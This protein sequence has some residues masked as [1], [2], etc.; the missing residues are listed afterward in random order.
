MIQLRGISKRFGDLWANADIDLDVRRGECHAVVGENGAGKTT[1]MQVLWG[2]WQPDRGEIRIEGVPKRFASPRDALRAGI[3]VVHQQLLVFPRLTAFENIVAGASPCRFLWSW[4]AAARSHI[5]RWADLFGFDLPLDVPVQELPFAQRQQIELLRALH[6]GA[7]ILILDEPTSLLA[8]PEV[9][10]LLGLLRSL[11][12]Q[13]RTLLFVSHRLSEVFALADTITVL[14]KGRRVV[15]LAQAETSPE[16]VAR[17]MVGAAWGEGSAGADEKGTDGGG[18]QTGESRRISVGVSLGDDA[19]FESRI[20]P[21]DRGGLSEAAAGEAA[22]FASLMPALELRSVSTAPTRDE[23][24]LRDVAL[25]MHPKEI[26]GIGG[27]VGNGQRSLAR[28]VAGLAPLTS[29]RILVQGEDWGEL[30][31]S[32]R[33]RRGFRLLPANLTEE[34]FCPAFSL[35]ENFL[36]GRHREKR[37][38]SGGWL[39]KSAARRWALEELRDGGVR[40]ENV[41]Q[42]LETLSGGN[43][44]RLGLVRVLTGSPRLLLLEQPGRGLDLSGQG[45]L[46]D[47]LRELSAGGASVLVISYD[48]DELMALCHR[49]GILYRGRLMGILP[50][51]ATARERLALWMTGVESC[52]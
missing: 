19:A 38:E 9:K 32:G 11:K 37:F 30:P 50:A 17:L 10:R 6:R 40:F 44:Q 49:I 35:W 2:R 13:G 28:A 51:C 7:R 42:P 16:T 41:N 4:R 3:G 39:R 48:L 18:I 21:L 12:D 33:L 15:S 36:L 45:W 8:P 26:V 47:R 5:L 29:G 34:G 20:A 52:C 31:L 22:A 27:V 24:G 46:Q 43:M 14:K 25:V 1:L 23:P